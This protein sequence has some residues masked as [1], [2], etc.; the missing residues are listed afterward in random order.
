MKKSI[1]ILFV[2][3]ASVNYSH[4]QWQQTNGPFSFTIRGLATHGT[5]LFAGCSNGVYKTTDGGNNWN[6]VNNGLP[7]AQVYCLAVNGSDIFAGTSAGLYKT[8]DDG[9]SWSAVNNNW[10]AYNILA[11]AIQ[12]NNIFVTQSNDAGDSA[13]VCLSTDYGVTWSLKDN[14]LI[15]YTQSSIAINDTDIFLGGGGTGMYLSTNNGGSWT[16][17]NNGLPADIGIRSIVINNTDV[18]AGTWGMGNGVYRTSNNGNSW[19]AVNGLPLQT[20][21]EAMLVYGNTIFTS[22][23]F[24]GVFISKDSGDN[25]ESWNSNDFSSEEILSFAV[26]DST[27]YAG[28]INGY[29]WKRSL[30]ELNAVDEIRD[31]CNI[32]VYPIPSSNQLTVEFKKFA[33]PDKQKIEIYDIQGRVLLRQNIAKEKTEIDISALEKGIYLLKLK[34]NDKAAVIR[35]V[36][37]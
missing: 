19:T 10:S 36:K 30:G 31:Y 28:D 5:T 24:W 9:N 25:W 20:N 32:A 26:M 1:F 4:S 37:E 18:F 6:P 3:T 8:S 33:F 16:L 35:F 22:T 2:F 17:I 29:V 23:D 13:G 27:M 12:G 21:A 15:N 34:L 14:G 7:A 11:I